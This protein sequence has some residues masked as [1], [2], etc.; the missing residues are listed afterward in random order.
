M[1][2]KTKKIFFI[3]LI[4]VLIFL[5]VKMG[6]LKTTLKITKKE[7]LPLIQI[8]GKLNKKDN[9]LFLV[10]EKGIIYTLNGEK[11]KEIEKYVG[12]TLTVF[13]EKIKSP[14]TTIENLPVYCGIKIIKYGPIITIPQMSEPETKNLLKKIENHTKWKESVLS[15]IGK[16]DKKDILEVIEGKISLETFEVPEYGKVD[17]LMLTT[18][19]KEKYFLFGKSA[20]FIKNNFKKYK[21]ETFIILGETIL[22]RSDYPVEK[23]VVTFRVKEVY[24]KDLKI[25][26]KEE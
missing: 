4:G 18:K 24:N 9:I 16:I 3:I 14:F 17:Y 15:K 10:S 12:E 22:P 1:N 21:D 26:L 13:G 19:E 25:I 5:V 8:F 11:T 6:I 20:D 7:F 2:K 23:D